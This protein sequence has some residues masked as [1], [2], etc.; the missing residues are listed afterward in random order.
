M[1]SGGVYQRTRGD[2]SQYTDRDAPPRTRNSAVVQGFGADY[3]MG[4]LVVS[5]TLGG[6][7]LRS[8]TAIVGQTLTE[9]YDATMV[10]GD[11]RLFVQRNATALFGASLAARKGGSRGVGKL[12]ALA[13]AGVLG[14][15]GHLGGHLSY[16]EGVG[17]D[18]TAF[19]EPAEDWTAARAAYADLVLPGTWRA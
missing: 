15:S 7:M 10:D 4:D 18:Q 19:E 14:A 3:R 16:A 8:S 12:L 6:L 13:G 11:P 1:G 9:R 2:D 5:G 17:V